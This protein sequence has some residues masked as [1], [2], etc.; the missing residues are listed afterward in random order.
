MR[1]LIVILVLLIATL[2]TATPANAW[3]R[4]GWGWG[5]GFRPLWRAT[6]PFAWHRGWG[7]RGYGY[8]GYGGGYPYVAYRRWGYPYYYRGYGGYGG[9]YSYPSY[10]YPSYYPVYSPWFGCYNT[11]GNGIGTTVNMAHPATGLYDTNFALTTNQLVSPSRPASPTVASSPITNDFAAPTAQ[12]LQRFLGLREPRGSSLQ[13]EPTAIAARPANSPLQALDDI[14]ARISTSEG[15]RK[16]E[17]LI[18]EGDELFRAQNFHSALQ[19]Y[20][21]AAS[22]APDLPEALWRK[23]HALVA[24][25]NYEQATT[26]FKRAIALTEDLSR[27]GFRLDDL[28]AGAAMTKGVHLE[29][30][31]EW[32]LSKKQSSDPY[33]LLGLFFTYD[34]QMTR[35]ERFFQKASDLAG[36]SGGHIAVFLDPPDDLS[37]PAPLPRQAT[38]P[39]LVLNTGTEI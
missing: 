10:Y 20:K 2:F 32:A 14:L 8:G 13:L 16:A 26:A 37:R 1:R 34:G 7:W 9:Y 27:D 38:T 35:A 19:K 15:R 11:S 30:L 23:G 36:I 6:H 22:D 3:W 18:R 12:A 21:L 33:F 28:Y 4:H 31:A 5:G 17:R 25:H 24:T 29:S 39:V